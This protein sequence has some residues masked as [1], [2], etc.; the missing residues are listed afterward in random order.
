MRRNIYVMTAM[1]LL[2]PILFLGNL[3]LG[4][5]AISP[6]DVAGIL[7]GHYVGSPIV[8]Y[9]VLESRLP[10]ALTAMLCGAVL[11]C[12]GLLL[13]SAFRNPLAGPG[14]FGISGGASLAVAIAMLGAGTLG[15]ELPQMSVL[16]AAFMGAMAVTAIILLVATVVRNNTLLLIVGIMIGYLAGSAITLLNFFA[17][18]QGVKSYAVWSMGSF[19]D[20]SMDDIPMFATLSIVG[21]VGSMLMAKPLN[22][23]QLGPQYAFGL[24]VNIR[25]TRLVLLAIT[26]LLVA[27][28]TAWCGPISFIGLAVPHIARLSIGSGNQRTLLPATALCGGVVG[29]LCNMLC[30]IGPSGVLPLNAVTPFIGAP[31]IIY[32]LLRRR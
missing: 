13:Q 29:L 1:A 30:N 3:F 5:V 26:G 20:V 10:Q 24:G 14:I 12:S 4:S 32:V 18:E 8:A 6:G 17:S 11:S 15:V 19:A 7:T 23:M 31:V 16:A 2:L 9:I 22:A 25:L 28:A 21:I 27:I